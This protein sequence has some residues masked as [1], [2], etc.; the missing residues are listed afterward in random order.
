MG[1]LNLSDRALERFDELLVDDLSHR[2]IDDL[3]LGLADAEELGLVEHAKRDAAIVEH[4]GCF[5]ARV[6]EVVDLGSLRGVSA[7]SA[8]AV[9]LAFVDHEAITFGRNA[10]PLCARGAAER[11]AGVKAAAEPA[12]E[13]RGQL[14]VDL[15][16]ELLA[17]VR[18]RVRLE[19]DGEPIVPGHG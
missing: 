14:G 1:E 3:V 4:L 2:S 5:H 9:V 12:L 13:R 15:A 18:K 8:D 17:P 11:N 19:H 6:E 7:A 10:D 16:L